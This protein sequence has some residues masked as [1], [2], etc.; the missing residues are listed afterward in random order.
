[1]KQKIASMS[2]FATAVCCRKW[3]D[4]QATTISNEHRAV[5]RRGLL[6]D[7]KATWTTVKVILAI[8][9]AMTTKAMTGDS[10]NDDGR[11]RIRRVVTSMMEAMNKSSVYRG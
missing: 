7:R 2:A 1:M 3:H 5:R 10:F 11:C 4:R 8:I 9:Y 6:D